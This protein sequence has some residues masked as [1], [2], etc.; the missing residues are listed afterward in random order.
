VSDPFLAEIRIVSFNFAPTN[1]AKCDGSLLVLSQNTA[2]FALLGTNYGGNG[3]T[4][5]A[6][7][8]FRDRAPL[9]VGAGNG[10]GL[11][12]HNVGE[13][14]GAASV[15]L[16]Q[17]EIPLHTHTAPSWTADNAVGSLVG[18]S[19]N[20]WAQAG[21]LRGGAKMYAS[22]AGTGLTMNG[23]AT[24]GSGQAHNNM[25]PY[26]TLNFIIALAGEFPTRP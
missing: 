13:T 16:I 12:S 5:F 8:D 14:G 2:L 25:P 22:S 17:S 26:L 1:W 19:G 6:L 20:V 10:P 9:H 7:P 23:L 15:T 24:S 3:S 4:N 18:P 11:S 21:A